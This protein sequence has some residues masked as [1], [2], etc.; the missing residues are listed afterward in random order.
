MSRRPD[1]GWSARGAILLA[2]LLAAG[3]GP[4]VSGVCDDLDDECPGYIPLD[5]CRDEGHR[6]EDQAESQGC[7]SVFDNYLDCIDLAQCDW[8]DECVDLRSELDQCLGGAVE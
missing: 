3:C 4:T 8:Y 5:D 7:E 1:F 2:A 6:L